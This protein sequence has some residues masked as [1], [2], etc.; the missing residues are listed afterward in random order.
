MSFFKQFK[1]G[2][3]LS[4]FLKD[5]QKRGIEKMLEG[6]LDAHL[7][8]D[9]HDR[10]KE[11]N[12]RNGYSSKK[13]KTS[14]GL[15]QIKIPR[16]REG[17]F[18]PMLIPKRK[19]MAEGIEN[20]IVSLYAKGMSVSDIEEQIR[21]V[22]EFD[23]SQSTISRITDAIT[24]DIVAWQNR[25]LE[26]VYLILWLDGIVFKVREGSKVINKTIYIGV[27]LR[28]DGHKEVLGLW[29]GK[30]ESASFWMSVLTD[31]KARGT[32]DILITATDNLNG[33]PDTIRTVLPESKT[34]ICVVH[35]I[36]NACR[37]V[38]WKDKK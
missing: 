3:E 10:C 23:V 34:Q 8:N 4:S 11:D 5:L 12:T 26:S 2:E 36:R 27:G 20:V 18:N 19:S 35:Q 9:K 15:D 16:D 29:L 33:F 1:T 17:S 6:E 7:D 14:Y 28:N 30:N 13:I 38:V 37:Y 22:Y 21:E 32:E 31:I 24:S 25:P